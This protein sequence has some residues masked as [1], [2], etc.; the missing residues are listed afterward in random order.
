MP[1]VFT[2]LAAHFADA[3]DACAALDRL[4]ALSRDLYW[5]HKQLDAALRSLESGIH[6][7]LFAAR[8]ASEPTRGKIL[9]RVKT[10]AY[11]LASFA[12]P[13]WDEAGIAIAPAQVALGQEAAKLNLRLAVEL[14]RPA[15]PLSRAHWM[16]G[17]HQFGDRDFASAIA[18][19]DAARASAVDAQSKPDELLAIAFAR[20]C[21]T[22]SDPSRLSSVEEALQ[23]LGTVEHGPDYVLQVTTARRVY[24]G[25]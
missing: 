19:F 12:W 6:I 14:N 23:Q 10:F 1:D 15:L 9:S 2:D 17:A 5:K 11:N 24:A 3:P 21:Q 22:I 16:L 7:G 20:L 4:D 13:G 8:D 25:V 18:S